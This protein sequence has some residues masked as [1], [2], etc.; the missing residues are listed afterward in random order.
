MAASQQPGR[1]GVPVLPKGSDQNRTPSL[2]PSF[3]E[4][5]QLLIQIQPLR[6]LAAETWGDPGDPCAVPLERNEGPAQIVRLGRETIPSVAA[7]TDGA[8]PI[9]SLP[10]R[11]SDARVGSLTTGGWPSSQAAQNQSADPAQTAPRFR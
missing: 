10:R 1:H 6:R 5:H 3:Q 2:W 9:R 8:P 7:G 11:F 4:R